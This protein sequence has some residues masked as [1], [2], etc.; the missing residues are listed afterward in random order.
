MAR[1]IE[2]PL[3]IAAGEYMESATLVDWAVTVGAEVAVGDI[4]ATVETA[5]AAS[6]IEA[7][8]AGQVAE[9]LVEA[10]QE[11]AIGAILCRL[12]V[13]GEAMAP[14]IAQPKPEAERVA[15]E[16]PPA[17][18]PPLATSNG[19]VRATP[20]AR[21]LARERGLDLAKA[22]LSARGWVKA[23]DLENFTADRPP[24]QLR[25]LLDELALA[26]GAQ[27]SLQEMGMEE[28]RAWFDG[29]FTHAW[30]R[31]GPPMARVEAGRL[32]GPG[33]SLPFRHYDPG[34][35]APAPALLYAHGGGWVMG[36]LESHDALCRRLASVAGL[37][38]IALDYRLAPEHRFPAAR[39]DV[40]AALRFLLENGAALGLDPARIGAAG[41]SA[42][43]QLVLSSLLALRDQGQ[44]LPGYAVL[45]YGA[46]AKPPQAPPADGSMARFGTPYYIL[47]REDID[48]F[49]DS[50]LPP[51]YQAGSDPLAEPL[52]ADHR[53]LPP[54]YLSVAGCDPLHDENVALAQRLRAAG[55]ET[56]LD[57][58]PGLCHG[59]LQKTIALDE[60]VV[61]MERIG[62]WI[63]QRHSAKRNRTA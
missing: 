57:V 53:G 42:G 3:A 4:L 12:R 5:K 38:V 52:L 9:L 19:F 56:E 43:A 14:E 36:G 15:R 29:P 32:Q 22:P 46:Y 40:A 51:D 45:L 63:R 62:R 49:W 48:W 1:Q 24:P 17:P 39:Q 41:D 10:G 31:D 61:A 16:P 37:R 7:P 23:S 8:E 30:N 34:V 54:I 33:G 20:L 25:L 27:Q 18:R 60:A 58:F 13:E 59:A 28:L 26:R 11:V 6:E 55:V 35:P 47:A 50:F 44:A 2:V 21:R